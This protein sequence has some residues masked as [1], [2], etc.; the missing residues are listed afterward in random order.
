[1]RTPPESPAYQPGGQG[2]P[3]TDGTPDRAKKKNGNNEPGPP[4]IPGEHC[5]N[6]AFRDRGA[7]QPGYYHQQIKKYH[8][9]LEYQQ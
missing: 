1:M 4:K 9:D 7:K 6:I 3:G 5:C 2:I 8:N